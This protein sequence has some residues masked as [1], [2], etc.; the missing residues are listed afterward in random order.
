MKHCTYK[1]DVGNSLQ[2]FL[3]WKG[4]KYCIFW[5]Y[6]CCLSYS[7]CSYNA[8]SILS[9]MAC[10]ALPIFSPHYFTNGTVFWK[11]LSQ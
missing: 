5:V 7:A 10:P 4:N 6:V 8:R 3:Q 11:K 9:S 2:P 1:R